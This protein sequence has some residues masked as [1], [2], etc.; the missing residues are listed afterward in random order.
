MKRDV[1]KRSMSVALLVTMILTLVLAV[2]A[3]A[4]DVIP[5]PPGP[6]TAL[7]DYA[8]A[9]AKAHPTANSG[10]PQNPLLA[11]NGFN[12][13]HLDTWNSDVADIAGPLGLNPAVVTSTFAEARQP[14]DYTDAPSWLFSC[15]NPN[16]DSHGRLL[17]TCVTPHQAT[18]VLADP[19]TLEV[20]SYYHFPVPPGDPYIGTGRQALMKSFAATT[21]TLMH[22][23]S[24]QSPQKARRSSR[25]S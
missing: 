12:S 24:L 3:G 5:I 18:S 22:M 11:P 20:L 23:I 25:L 19:D 13:C 7:P 9:P 1:R 8:G 10:V 21:S 16:V 15:F 2:A 14:I 4:E 6:E 17:T